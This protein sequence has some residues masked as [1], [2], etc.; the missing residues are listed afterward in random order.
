MNDVL[1]IALTKPLP[2]SS[3]RQPKKEQT[4]SQGFFEYI[5]SSIAH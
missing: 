1:R 5:E 2:R 3:R 4:Q